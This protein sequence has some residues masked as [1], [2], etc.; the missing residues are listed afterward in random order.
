LAFDADDDLFLFFAHKTST[1]QNGGERQNL[2]LRILL[3]RT[4]SEG[5]PYKTKP[6][7]AA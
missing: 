4:A 1:A 7:R 2:A 6:K 3:K 5:G